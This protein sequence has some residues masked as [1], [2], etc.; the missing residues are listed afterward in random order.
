MEFREVDCGTRK[1][2][3]LAEHRDV[4]YLLK[5]LVVVQTLFKRTDMLGL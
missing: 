1:L 2:M 3:D 4:S 5:F